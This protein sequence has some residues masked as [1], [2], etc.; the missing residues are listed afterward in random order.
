MTLG[1][2]QYVYDQGYRLAFTIVRLDAYRNSVIPAN[3]LTAISNALGRARQAGL[4]V[5]PRFVYNYPES[6]TEYRNA[7]DAPL[8]RV[9]EH[10][11]QLKPV[12][13]ANADV[14]AYFQAGF[15]GA[16]G[17]W[18]TSSNNLTSQASMASVRDALLDAL[19]TS[20][21]LQVRYPGALMGWNATV[22]PGARIGL[23]NDCFMSSAT[24]VG[25]YSDNPTT[26]QAQ[27][28]YVGALSRVAPF[29]GETC[30][31]A[32]EQGAVPRTSCEDILREGAEFGLTF[33]N[34]SYYTTLFH[35]NWQAL[36][37]FDEVKRKM[38]YRVELVSISHSGQV[39]PGGS[40]AISLTV[41]N[42]GWARPFNSRPVQL[43]LK[44]QASGAVQLVALSGVD[45]S[46]WAPGQDMAL[47]S[48]IS[49]PTSMLAGVYDVHIAMPDA[50][51]TLRGDPRYSVRPANAS[52][53]EK[54]QAWDAQLG[55]FRT[56]TSI[57]VQ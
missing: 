14:I 19:P 38:G 2:A 12:F 57:T 30:N 6:E 47:R 8:P 56:G 23:H 11:A 3:T 27:R 52:A 26:R 43:V 24:D 29:G 16:W 45:I 49:L 41:R 39:S 53:S 32:D 31:P 7:Q 9:L 21:Y 42:T 36:G 51:T 10:I 54:N 46:S 1:D 4:K 15:I 37:C 20:R 18:H 5:I 33:L 25:T 22:N 48:S 44:H 28:S 50:A 34:S 13:Q 17:E 40:S 55:A 35:N